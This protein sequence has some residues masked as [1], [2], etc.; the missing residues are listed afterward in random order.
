MQYNIYNRKNE[1][2]SE[3]KRIEKQYKDRECKQGGSMRDCRCIERIK[4][5]LTHYANWVKI[6]TTKIHQ[7]GVCN[8]YYNLS[9]T[10]INFLLSLSR[11][12][13]FNLIVFV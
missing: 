8:L 1:L 5:M 2:I 13:V 9:Q 3:W 11:F 4:F 6:R 10:K 7:N 12:R